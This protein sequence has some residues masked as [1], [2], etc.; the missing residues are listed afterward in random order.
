MGF[1][2]ISRSPQCRA[3]QPLDATV[4]RNPH[5]AKREGV[6]SQ[7][8]RLPSPIL[9][10]RRYTAS[11]LPVISL[12]RVLLSGLD[13]HQTKTV[14]HQNNFWAISRLGLLPLHEYPR[15]YDTPSS[16]VTYAV[17]SLYRMS[18]PCIVN[19]EPGGDSNL[20]N[21]SCV[22]SSNPYFL[23]SSQ[24]HDSFRPHHARPSV[25]YFW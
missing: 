19:L 1:E 17:F 2:P 10:L 3:S 14:Y 20:Q 15:Q 23:H 9:L 7:L 11:L 24:S 16:P 22:M 12:I 4:Y 13:Q 8:R 21:V 25:F 5:S 18:T 6:V